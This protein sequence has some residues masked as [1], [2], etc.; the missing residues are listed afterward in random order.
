MT[1]QRC[2]V[3]NGTHECQKPAGHSGRHERVFIYNSKPRVARWDDKWSRVTSAPW[4]D[5]RLVAEP[6]TADD[7]RHVLYYFRHAGGM[8]PG[9]FTELILQAYQKAD[10]GNRRRL[11]Q[12]FPGFAAAMDTV[13]RGGGVE[14]LARRADELEAG[15]ES[16]D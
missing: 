7:A 14:E 16:G 6:M 10:P 9:G 4:T 3:S 5:N 15:N 13:L 2:A 12:G 11:R 8:Q 1:E